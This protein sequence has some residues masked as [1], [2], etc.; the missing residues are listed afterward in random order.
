MMNSLQTDIVSMTSLN[1][2]RINQR[3]SLKSIE[4]LSSGSA[5]HS[6][7]DNA[8]GLKSTNLMKAQEKSLV[9]AL[10]N[11]HSGITLAQTADSALKTVTESL[12]RMRELAVQASNGTLLSDQRSMLDQEYQQLMSE[13]LTIVEDTQWNDW[14]LFKKLDS[15]SF[16]IQAGAQANETLKIEI[17]QVLPGSVSSFTNGDFESGSVGDTSANGWTITNSRVTLD[18][19]ST[20]GGFPTPSDSTKPASS[21]GDAVSVTGGPFSSTLVAAS[22]DQGTQSLRMTS[23]GLQVAQG[24]GITHGPYVISNQAVA[25][26]SGSD[27]TFDW[28]AEGGAD[29]YDVYAY[30]LNVDDGSTVELL[31]QTGSGTA[32]SGWQ[33]VS[34]T[35][36]TTGNYKFVFVSGTFDETGGRALGAQL[37][38]DNIYAPPTGNNTIVATNLQSQTSAAD[39][40]SELDLNIESVD[41]AR[42]SLAASLD[43]MTFAVD[44]LLEYVKNTSFSRSNIAD[45]NY[46]QT[47]GDLA[48][49]QMV[50]Q[51]AQFVMQQVRK[52]QMI[53]VE[54]IQNNDRL[55]P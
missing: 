2:M 28:K 48:K 33:S 6:A 43:R 30:L 16:A 39:A 12:Q 13:V 46:L 50:D 41:F 17:P 7:S 26:E 34:K 3:Q 15:T 20:I 4:K 21:P 49:T 27:V 23:S 11:V 24:Y 40:L 9:M 18:G 19:L 47:S 55:T 35:I 1:Q 51:A 52:N 37:F 36:P 53:H 42:A 10:Q 38:I 29:A 31:N 5:I 22:G 14:K 25:I 45:T 44:H 32:S 8:A 54:I